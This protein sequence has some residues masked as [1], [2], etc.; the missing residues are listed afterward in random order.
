MIDKTKI[1]IDKIYKADYQN[2]LIGIDGYKEIFKNIE[3]YCKKDLAFR[4]RLDRDGI[5]PDLFNQG[6]FMVCDDIL[7]ILKGEIND[8]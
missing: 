7:K 2:N 1:E 6:R 4:R 3:E 8:I 5:T